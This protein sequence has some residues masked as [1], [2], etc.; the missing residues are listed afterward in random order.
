MKLFKIF[1]NS[2]GLTNQIFSIINAILNANAENH[3]VVVLDAFL[4]D[5][6]NNL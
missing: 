2:S 3:R 1:K 6:K 4:D 5:I